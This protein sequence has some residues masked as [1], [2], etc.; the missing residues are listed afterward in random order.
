MPTYSLSPTFL[1]VGLRLCDMGDCNR[2]GDLHEGILQPIFHHPTRVKLYPNPEHRESHDGV[3][4]GIL[5]LP[6]HPRKHGLV[7]SLL[8][9]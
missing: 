6:A 9:D 8:K 3:L 1:V 7:S 4:L 5:H 2:Q